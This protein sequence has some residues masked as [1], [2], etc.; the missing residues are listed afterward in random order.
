M[1]QITKPQI[2]IIHALLNKMNLM[3]GKQ[4]FVSEFTNGR[5]E[6]ISLME[7]KEATEF[8]MRLKTLEQPSAE[9]VSRERMARNILAM[10]HELGWITKKMIADQNG[11]LKEVNDY[12]PLNQWLAV[13]GYLKKPLNKYTYNELPKLVSQFKEVYKHYMNKK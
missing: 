7:A 5:T 3:E 11:K 4:A 12:T 10:A 9:D 2:Q 1:S 8:I 13:H 6:R